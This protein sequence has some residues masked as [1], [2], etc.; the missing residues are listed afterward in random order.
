MK[1]IISLAGNWSFKLD[2][3][4]QENLK[5]SI[6]LPGSTDEAGYGEEN[7]IKD[8]YRLSKNNQYIGVAWYEKEVEIGEEC[9]NKSII[10]FLERCHWETKVWIDGIEVGMNDSLCTPHQVDVSNFMSVGKHLLTIR[11]DNSIKYNVGKD[12]HSVTM[13]TQTNWNGIIGKIQLEIYDKVRIIDVEVYPNLDKK[14]VKVY[15]TVENNSRKELNGEILIK[16]E[17]W[18]S[19]N[20]YE[21]KGKSVLFNLS[22]T[23]KIIQ[24]DYELGENINLW[25][26]FSPALYKLNL[27]IKG[28]D[29]FEDNTI[30]DF[31]MREFKTEKSQFMIN[32]RTTFLRGTLEC[33]VFPLTGYPAVDIKTWLNIF[34][35]A[36]SYGLNHMRF[37]SWCPPEAAF[38]AADITGFML[39]IET[40]VWTVLGEDSN[41]DDFIYKEG[42][43]I[44]KEYGNHPSFCMLA[45][46]NEPSGE[47]QVEFLSKIVAYWKEKDSRRL[48][49]G[50]AGWPEIPE[51]NYHC[52]K[53]RKEVLRC[54]DWGAE[55][56]GRLNAGPYDSK[57]DFSDAIA[58]CKVPI[59]SHEIGQWCAY[60]NLKEIDKYKGVLKPRNFQM[61]QESLLKN[62]MIHQKEDFLLASGKLQTMLYKADIEVALRT[63]GFG[64]FQLLGL[65]DF[66]GQGTALV[67]VLDVF[68]QSKGYV[69]GEEYSR[70]C[71]ETVPLLRMEKV[72]WKNSETFEGDIEIANFGA[73][74]IKDAEVEWSAA[75]KDGLIITCGSLK[76]FE[77]PLGNNIKVMKV[78]LPLGSVI[79]PAEII[80]TVDIKGTKYINSW[81]I[82]V[83]SEKIDIEIPNDIIIAHS[84]KEVFFQLEAGRKVL[85]LANQHE[86]K[87]NEV[88]LGFT[89]IFWNTQWTNGQKPH[90]LG[91]LCDSKNPVFDNFVTDNHTNW[92]W[93]DLINSSKPL[94]LND[95]S[96]GLKPLIQVIDDWNENRKIGLLFEGKVGPG[97]LIMS[98]IDLEKNIMDRPVAKQLLCSI[99]KYMETD[100]FNPKNEITLKQM[101][102]LCKND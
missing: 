64:G 33:C 82:W 24:V 81:S 17:T 14:S 13:E 11:V 27:C 69:S 90:T 85:F 84:I 35:T 1:K 29:D 95:F 102:T 55:L 73:S 31:G 15:I 6:Y 86:L 56:N 83:F 61:A 10:L 26:E 2:L 46:G 37:H 43:R 99:I 23:I 54:Q 76:P 70:F 30:I 93:F 96:T 44:L 77:I 71:C 4:N 89:S 68:W 51:N 87:I 65:T 19:N 63:P 67:G 22:K 60:P 75:Y 25:D 16:A 42:D 66:P 72:V 48:Y 18:N 9:I 57:F 38:C 36:K 98:S 28:E 101:E 91:I 80:I 40:P 41:L 74:C 12:A 34:N 88:G 78:S 100:E 92:H 49:T 47:N 52:L 21:M 97:K 45:V 5:K 59:V 32:G 3:E 79:T 8:L 62:N 7:N 53:N 58:G 20:I 94:V 39:Q 50:T